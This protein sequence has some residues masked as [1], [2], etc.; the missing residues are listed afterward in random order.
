MKERV[1]Y[2]DFLR[3]IAIIMVIGIHA[4][5]LPKDLTIS[6][7]F[8]LLIRQVLNCAV[9]LFFAISGFFCFPKKLNTNN[10]WKQFWRR[11]ISKVYI[12]TIIL[13]LPLYIYSIYSGKNF[14]ISTLRLLICGY[15]IYYFVAV[16]I[17]MYLLLPLLKNR[18]FKDFH[19]GSIL[20]SAL[21][22]FLTIII[23]TYVN[24]I[25]GMHLPLILY[26]GTAFL[27]IIFFILGCKLSTTSRKHS[28][29]LS[30]FLALAGLIISYYESAYLMHNYRGGVGIKPSSFLFSI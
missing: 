29:Y 13:S 15:S 28:L 3:G 25:Q 11:Q 21:I 14:Y 8:S 20:V 27:W 7:E 9:P 22:S 6:S 23:V 17:Q 30:F 2:F 16:T 19:N 26:A 10:E 18:A 4:Y 5:I 24:I 1:G 12:P